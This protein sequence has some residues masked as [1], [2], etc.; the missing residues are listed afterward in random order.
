M[1]RAE[2]VSRDDKG[3]LMDDENYGPAIATA[4]RALC[5]RV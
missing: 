5:V 1:M 4:R 2:I 3:A